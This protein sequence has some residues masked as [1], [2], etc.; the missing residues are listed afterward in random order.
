MVRIHEAALFA[1]LAGVG[2]TSA[3]DNDTDSNGFEAPDK[4]D[5]GCDLIEE[6]TLAIDEES[7]IRLTGDDVLLR[8]EGSHLSVLHYPDGSSLPIQVNVTYSAG[9]IVFYDREIIGS[10]DLDVVSACFDAVEVAVVIDLVSDDGAFNELAIPAHLVGIIEDEASWTATIDP[11]TLSGTYET[12]EDT[13]GYDT[14]EFLIEGEFVVQ[15]SSGLI[16]GVGTT[17][18]EE[19]EFRVV[20]WK[21][22]G[23]TG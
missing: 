21:A 18:E 9:D 1:L 6:I 22:P 17:G 5:G 8:S 12:T 3:S 19:T 15:G 16:T 10:P 14:V 7:P 11:A 20:E 4:T 13:S 2:C 23:E